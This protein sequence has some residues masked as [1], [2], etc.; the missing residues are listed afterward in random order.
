[1]RK[2]ARI[3]ALTVF[4]CLPLFALAQEPQKGQTA[5][6]LFPL[7]AISNAE[8]KSSIWDGNQW[9]E[10]DVIVE[11]TDEPDW[12]LAGF[13]LLSEVKFEKRRERDRDELWNGAKHYEYEFKNRNIKVFVHTAP[14]ADPGPLLG[15][16]VAYTEAER[17]AYLQDLYLRLADAWLTGSLA[18][19]SD[20]AKLAVMNFAHI[21]AQGSRVSTEVFRDAEYLAVDLGKSD[22]VLNTIQM[23]SEAERVA[24]L[25]N[26][27]LLTVLKG[28]NLPVS[29]GET[30]AGVKLQIELGHRNFV[31]EQETTFDNV[32]IYATTEDIKAFTDFDITS[33]E[34]IDR[35]FVIVNGNRV[36]V[37][38]AS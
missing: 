11:P 7:D 13:P 25:L 15:Q 17:D 31:R 37:P 18:E 14:N 27:Q 34:L 2:V 6:L 12:L 29:D 22:V 23:G 19:L 5:W 26:E 38:L 33:Q 30:V 4:L 1:M 8:T 35:S 10:G 16:V 32:E 24:W 9:V 36:S 3:L 28:F 21:V 20:D